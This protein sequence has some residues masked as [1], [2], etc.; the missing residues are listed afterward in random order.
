MMGWKS[1]KELQ[2]LAACLVL[3]S[4]CRCICAVGAGGKTTLLT[5]LAQQLARKGKKV[6]LTTTTKMYQ[7][8]CHGLLDP[9]VDQLQKD[10][11]DWGWVQ[12][13]SRLD[14]GKMGPLSAKIWE[15]LWKHDVIF[16]VEADG[17]H[18][19]PLKYP[20]K[21]EPVLP[22]K[23]DYLIVMAGMTGLGQP[24]E[25]VCHRWEQQLF[26]REGQPVDEA[27]VRQLLTAGYGT[28][29]PGKGCYVLNQ[30]DMLTKEEKEKM[31]QAMEGLFWL[32]GSLRDIL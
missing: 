17:S 20:A 13:G 29:L 14:Q 22:A 28:L 25:Q 6:L 4:Q 16:L 18:R 7:Q 32:G 9:T 15:E 12:A 19:L 2:D 3:P 30:A 5:A 10:L 23:C 11:A 1:K 8:T 24:V 27:L 21:H 31:A 26:W